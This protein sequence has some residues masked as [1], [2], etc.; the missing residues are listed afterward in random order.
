MN[1]RS[2]KLLWDI[3][4]AGDFIAVRTTALSLHDFVADEVLRLAVERQF[5][6]IGE[7]A[8]RL[9]A[10]NSE[11]AAKLDQL[12]EII[13]FRNLIAHGYDEI[14]YERLLHIAKGPLRHLLNQVETVLHEM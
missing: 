1:E 6:I 12:S 14:D 2:K 8:R 7:A 5:E 4:T 11:L 10:D 3:K 9:A 13:S